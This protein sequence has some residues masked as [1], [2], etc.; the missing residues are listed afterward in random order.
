M[1]ENQAK[2]AFLAIGSSLGNKERNICLAKYKLQTNGIKII[3]SSNNYETLSWPNI[4]HPNYINTVIKISTNLTPLKLM[5][6]CLNIEKELGR[7][8]VKKNEPRICDIDI[9]DYDQKIL[10]IISSL[11]LILPHPEMHKRNF[12]L[13][14]LFEIAKSWIHP[15]KK[16]EVK[17][18]IKSLD[19][20]DLRSIKLV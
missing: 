11:K 4:K 19:I 15:I 8:R 12:V 10:K 2:M 3:K 5:Q 13:L 16:K 6:K 1:L 17:N 14:P 7:K 20:K 18:L 9:I